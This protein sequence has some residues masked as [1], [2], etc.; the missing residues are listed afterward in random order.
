M[1]SNF[2]TSSK[3]KLACE[4]AADRVLAGRISERGDM[5]EMCAAERCLQAA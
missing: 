4:I 1:R 5:V 3:P 2:N